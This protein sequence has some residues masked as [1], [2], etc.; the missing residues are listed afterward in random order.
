[1]NNFHLANDTNTI[2]CVLK[3]YIRIYWFEFFS[4]FEITDLAE[5]FSTYPVLYVMSHV[6][7]ISY[8]LPIFWSSNLPIFRS[9]DLPIFISSYLLIFRSS[10][11]PIFRIFHVIWPHTDPMP[12]IFLSTAFYGPVRLIRP[13]IS[14]C[15]L[16]K[17]SLD[18][19][20]LLSP[21]SYLLDTGD[22]HYFN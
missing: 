10:D 5:P 16:N 14:R 21:Y 15:N 12:Y 11:L 3:F 22:S 4:H 2:E 17:N 6:L 19:L 18:T 1:M 13:Y 20:P 9:S 8:R 7:T